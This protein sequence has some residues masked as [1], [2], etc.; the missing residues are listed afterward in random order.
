MS[1]DYFAVGVI[2][3]ECMYGRRPYV[4][5][6]RKE[7]RDHILSKQIQIRRNEVPAGWS[8]QAADFV[9][10]MIQRKPVY[11]LGLNGPSEVKEHPW[12]KNFPWQDLADKKI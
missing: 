11:R 10:K 5:K 6:C 3:F 4:G 1:V 7:I 2:A 9:N 8:I 12:L